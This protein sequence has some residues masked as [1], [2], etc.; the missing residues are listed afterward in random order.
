VAVGL[1]RLV[2]KDLRPGRYLARLFFAE[3]EALGRKHR[4]Q[5]I[6][7]QG[8]NVLENFD[9]INEAGG[10]MRGVIKEFASIEVESDFTLELTAA[11]GKT[12]ISGIELVRRD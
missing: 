10:V 9:L 8:R 6:K 5:D 11:N 3:S 2:I 12:I 4:L 7:I 1:E